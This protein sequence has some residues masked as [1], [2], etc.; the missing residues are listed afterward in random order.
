MTFFLWQKSSTGAEND[1]E[2]AGGENARSHRGNYLVMVVWWRW[3]WLSSHTKILGKSFDDSIPLAVFLFFFQLAPPVPL[4]KPGSVHS[5]S[6][7]RDYCGRAFPDEARANS[8]PDHSHTV[9]GQHSQSSEFVKLGM[10]ACLGVTCH[11]H[12]WQKDR[13][14][15]TCHWCNTRDGTDTE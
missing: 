1:A 11:L 6:E 13:N 3:Q 2:D 15:F 4:C 12:F 5:G 8:L 9:P 10:Y 14:F 7:S